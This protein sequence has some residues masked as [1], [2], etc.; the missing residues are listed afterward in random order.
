[1]E[2]AGRGKGSDH[3]RNLQSQVDE[4]KN[5]MTQ[6]VERILA[7]GENLNHLCNKTEDLEG[8]PAIVRT[9]SLVLP[10]GMLLGHPEAP[11]SYSMPQRAPS[12]LEGESWTMAVFH[13]SLEWIGN[14][15]RTLK[16][17]GNL[18][19]AGEQ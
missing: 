12:S 18:L 4:V 17:D 15:P 19:V 13:W 3:V 9:L 16:V 2:E 8:P 7:Q 6:N 5:I 14:T 11:V 10:T 1:M